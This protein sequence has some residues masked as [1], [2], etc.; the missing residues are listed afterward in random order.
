MK[1]HIE[2]LSLIKVNTLHLHLTE[3]QAWRI[4]IDAFPRLL[5]SAWRLSPCPPPAA[6]PQSSCSV[7]MLLPRVSSAVVGVVFVLGCICV[8]VHVCVLC[9]VYR[10]RSFCGQ[11]CWKQHTPLLLL[12]RLQRAGAAR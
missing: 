2:V 9:F 10:L 3:D 7:M 11:Y 8:H 4:A 6:L 12:A 1:R 5:E